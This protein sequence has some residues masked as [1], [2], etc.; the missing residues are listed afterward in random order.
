MEEKGDEQCCVEKYLLG[1]TLNSVVH[2]KEGME[3]EQ[4]TTTLIMGS[5]NM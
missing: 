2:K 4:E 1:T 5:L 3:C